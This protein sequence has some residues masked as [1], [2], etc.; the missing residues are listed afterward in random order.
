ML[1]IDTRVVLDAGAQ[2]LRKNDPDSLVRRTTLAA[3]LVS[4]RVVRNMDAGILSFYI[5]N[6]P[7][8]KAHPPSNIFA[9]ANDKSR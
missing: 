8:A 1:S 4:A 3:I 9:V 6:D 5:W 2:S 7:A